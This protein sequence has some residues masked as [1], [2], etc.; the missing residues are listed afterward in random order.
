MCLSSVYTS[1]TS[2]SRYKYLNPAEIDVNIQAQLKSEPSDVKSTEMIVWMDESQ[3]LHHQPA[4]QFIKTS[5][6]APTFHRKTDDMRILIRMMDHF[7][8]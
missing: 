5:E 8:S 4:V 3:T 7:M 1:D 6:K 2:P